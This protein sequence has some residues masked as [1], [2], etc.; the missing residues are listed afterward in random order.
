MT[1]ALLHQ[2][3]RVADGTRYLRVIIAQGRSDDAV[4]ATLAHELQHAI[5]LLDVSLDGGDSFDANLGDLYQ[6]GSRL[7][8]HETE[9]AMQI[10]L[11]VR[12]ELQGRRPAS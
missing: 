9:R 5:E 12:R 7:W 1:G 8:V 10:T 6:V 11:A 2:V 4:I 3:T